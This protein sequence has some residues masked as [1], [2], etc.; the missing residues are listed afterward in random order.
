MKE[1][2]HISHSPEET[3]GIARQ[4]VANAPGRLLLALHGELGSG[5]TCFVKG[6]ALA[7]GID[8]PIISPTFTIVREYRGRKPLY[9]VDL[10]RLNS[11]DEVLA[12]GFEEYLQ[13]DGV[14]AVEWA[15]RAGDLIPQQAIRIKFEALSEPDERAITV[16]LPDDHNTGEI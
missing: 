14:T 13:A 10:Y 11:P 12:I 16:I 5:K 9:H 2:R 7:L 8:Q 1:Q 15:E 3:W 4:L 6:I